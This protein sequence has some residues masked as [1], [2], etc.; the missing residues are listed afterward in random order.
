VPGR[1]GQLLRPFHVNDQVEDD[2]ALAALEP[3]GLAWVHEETPF[4][5]VRD[6]LSKR[7]PKRPVAGQGRGDGPISKRVEKPA[8]LLLQSPER[9]A[10]VAPENSR[11]TRS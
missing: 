5:W 2:L 11:S 10:M 4:A 7:Y 1:L 6:A 3:D 9:I 8:I